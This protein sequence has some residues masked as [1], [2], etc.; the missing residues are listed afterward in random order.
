V[1]TKR[2]ELLGVAVA[3]ALGALLPSAHADESSGLDQVRSRGALRVAVYN[4]FPP[5]SYDGS[6][7]IDV[8]LAQALAERIGVKAEIAWFNADEDMND[9]LRNMV[10]KGHYLGGKPGDVMMHVPQDRH[11]AAKNDKVKI[12]GPYHQE[13]L[14]MARVASRIPEPKGSAAAALEVFTREK[15]GVETAT[16]S[17]AFLLGV[18][19]GRL[20]DNVA[21]FRSVALAV[22]GL[23]N[24]KVA[25]VMAPR[26]ELENNLK[27][28]PA[29]PVSVVQMQELRVDGWPLAMAVKRDDEALAKTLADAM[30]SLH[31]DG[32]VERIFRKYG[33][34]HSAPQAHEPD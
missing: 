24:D 23:R 12:F 1:S 4:D 34:T 30:L 8:E 32:T 6:K 33:I 18:L 17:D 26:S 10:W 16:G 2:R 7:G 11:F 9:D 31:R 25:A 28:D 3:L 29:Y 5:Y 27:G 13:R 14:A 22:E 21:H 20:R 19:N 15:I